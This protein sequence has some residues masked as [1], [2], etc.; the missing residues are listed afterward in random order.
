MLPRLFEHDFVNV[1][2]I[3]L[4]VSVHWL[5]LLRRFL[6]FAFDSNLLVFG[7]VRLFCLFILVELKQTFNSCRLVH[8]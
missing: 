4:E 5:L 3:H 6:F 2:Q 8:W 7:L 1:A